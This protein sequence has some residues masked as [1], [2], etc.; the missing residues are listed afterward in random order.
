MKELL[1]QYAE[2]NAWAN[3]PIIDTLSQLSEE[4]VDKEITSSFPSLRA[5]AM[6]TLGAEFIW[7][8]RLQLAEHPVWLPGSFQGT[9][10]EACNKWQS[11]SSDFVHFVSDQGDD[12]ALMHQCE[13]KDRKGAPY[14]MPV[15]H[16]L[17][18]VFNH[19]TYHRGQLVTMLR[20]VGVTTIPATDFIGYARLKA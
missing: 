1:L 4:D 13:F 6:H 2:Y 3:K 8:Q 11:V 9:F 18:H 19:S 16:I 20:Q 17:Q 10:T 15:Y 5:T 12:K 14:K 7:L